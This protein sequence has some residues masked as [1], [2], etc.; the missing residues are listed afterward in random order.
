M[1]YRVVIFL[2][3][4]EMFQPG[5]T[6]TIEVNEGLAV[7]LNLPPLD[8]VPD[9]D[10]DWKQNNS[11]L[12]AESIYHHVTLQKNLVL[13]SNSISDS[14]RQFQARAVNGF[15]G[16]GSQSQSHVFVINIVGEC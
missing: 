2:S 10:I 3:D 15:S 8:S 5:N 6:E 16:A 7:I 11:T 14:G 12:S 4:M 1:P 13:L 9:P